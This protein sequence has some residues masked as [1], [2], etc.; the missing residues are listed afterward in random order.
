MLG[1]T[2]YADAIACYNE[3][4]IAN[5]LLLEGIKVNAVTN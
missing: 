5:M 3:I 4:E 2:C 1:K